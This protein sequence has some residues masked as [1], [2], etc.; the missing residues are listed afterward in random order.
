MDRIVPLK[1]RPRQDGHEPYD[2]IDL[3]NVLRA[4]TGKPVFDARLLEKAEVDIA[5]LQDDYE[6]W[7][8]DAL[9][10]LKATAS[11]LA[12]D[13]DPPALQQIFLIAHDLRGLA[14]GFGYPF[15]TDI[16]ALLCKLVCSADQLTPKLLTAIDA[17]VAAL[18]AVIENKIQGPS[19]PVTRQVLASLQQLGAQLLGE[20]GADTPP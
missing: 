13:R 19:D 10:Q 14:G 8:L 17:H 15:A 20:S 3:P 16:A 18:A 1:T 7:V 5:A 9:A 6:A 11:A 2:V 12:V 4:K